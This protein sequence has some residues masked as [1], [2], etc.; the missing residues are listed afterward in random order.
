MQVE[1]HT[2]D[3]A[4]D[5]ARLQA[6]CVLVESARDAGHEVLLWC[7]DAAQQRSL[8]DLLWSFRDRSF[9]PHT[10]LP[11]GAGTAVPVRLHLG[12]GW[13]EAGGAAVVV[14]LREAAVPADCPATRVI[15]IIDGDPV[16]RSAGRERF[17]AYR[18]RGLAP[19]HHRFDIS[20]QG[21]NG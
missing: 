21:G 13:P 9:I 10:C 19:A 8:D 1:F 7:E 6:A 11:M 16:R 4:A 18:E 3:D 5:T 17:K 20:S 2:L 14:N 12:A 15:E